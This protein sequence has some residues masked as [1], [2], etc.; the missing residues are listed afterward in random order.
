MG[1]GLACSLPMLPSVLPIANF[2]SNGSAS[3]PSPRAFSAKKN[4]YPSSRIP[5]YPSPSVPHVISTTVSGGKMSA[6]LTILRANLETEV[7]A[8]PSQ[9]LDPKSQ[10]EG[11]L[12]SGAWLHPTNKFQADSK[13]CKYQA[14]RGLNK[15]NY[16]FFKQW[17]W[18]PW[19]RQWISR[20][21]SKKSDSSSSWSLFNVLVLLV[22][23]VTYFLLLTNKSKILFMIV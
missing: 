18:E 4:K 3:F 21:R 23:L 7:W 2:S 1:T 8:K 13:V 10:A 6:N 9:T 5:V 22:E 14:I 19:T 16:C 15:G 17:S 12:Q 20:T 11:Y